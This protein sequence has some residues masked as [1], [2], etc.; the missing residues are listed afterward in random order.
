[1]GCLL[2]TNTT[3]CRKKNVQFSTTGVIMFLIEN[4][5]RIETTFSHN[6]KETGL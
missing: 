2:V 5:R 1:M 6:N 4:F 3:H